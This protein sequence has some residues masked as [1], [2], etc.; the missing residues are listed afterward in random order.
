MSRADR[1]SDWQMQRER[2]ACSRPAECLE[3]NRRLLCLAFIR[4]ER[5][6]GLRRRAARR[7][8]ARARHARARLQ[9]GAHRPSATARSTRPSRAYPHRLHYAHQGQF[10]ARPS[11]ACMRELGA[12]RRRQLRRRDRRRAARRFRARSR[13][14]SPASARRAPSS[15]G[16]SALGLRRDQRRVAGRGASASRPSRAARGT[17]ARVAIRINPDVDAGSHPHISTGHARH[18]VRHVGRRGAGDGRATSSRRPRLH[19]VGLHVHVGSQITDARA[20]RPRGR[21]RWPPWRA[22]WRAQACRSSISISAAGSALRT[23]PAR[24][25]LS[26]EDYAAA[27]AAGRARRRGLPLVL[28]PGR[29]IVG[30][31]GVLVT[32]SS[33]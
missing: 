1:T 5:R 28:E 6:P 29:W 23:S 3:Y 10:D 18:Q 12:R 17:R 19:L 11:C 14:C 16:R 13:S 7:D 26:P 32:R 2:H 25:V 20:A 9:R 21:D 8:R 15:S 22:S 30:P 4:T 33:T 24:P 27:D 31:A